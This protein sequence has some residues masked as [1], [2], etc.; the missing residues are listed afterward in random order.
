MELVEGQTLRELLARGPLPIKKLLQIAPQIARGTRARA[1]GRDRP[2]GPEAR[3]RDGH[4]GRARQDPGLRPRE[5]ESTGSG[6]GE[7]S[8]LPTMTGTQPGVVVGTV[9]YMSPEQARGQAVD[10]RSDQFSFGSMLYEMATGK[11]AFQKKTAVDTLA[12]ILNE[13]PEPIAAVNPQMPAP[14]ALDRRTMPRQGAGRTLRVDRRP[15]P[16]ARGPPRSPVG[17]IRHCRDAAGELRRRPSS[18]QALG[19]VLAALALLGGG[20]LISESAFATRQRS[21]VSRKSRFSVG[22]SSEPVSRPTV[23][24]SYTQ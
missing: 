7:A 11:R 3:E 20:Y 10:F 13:E 2:P 16:R 15:G 17:G 12:A 14:A 1:R 19:I 24:P 18:K 5:A 22:R 21:C 9:G 8:Q 4:E 23:R 6:S